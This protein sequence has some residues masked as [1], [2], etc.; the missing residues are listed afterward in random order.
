MKELNFNIKAMIGSGGGHG[1]LDF[2]KATGSDSDGVFSG[3]FPLIKNPKSLDP[4]LDPPLQ[5]GFRTIQ[6]KIRRLSGPP[7]NVRFYRRVGVL[8]LRPQ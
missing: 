3:D 4:N 6:A 7:R 1:L 8:S 5:N 2:A